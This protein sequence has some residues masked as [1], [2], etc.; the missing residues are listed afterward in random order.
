MLRPQKDSLSLY[1]RKNIPCLIVGLL[2]MGQVSSVSVKLF[3]GG[4]DKR[5]FHKRYPYILHARNAC[6]QLLLTVQFSHQELTALFALSRNA[7]ISDYTHMNTTHACAHPHF[8]RCSVNV[9]SRTHVNDMSDSGTGSSR[10][11]ASF[12]GDC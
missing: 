1:L 4:Y 11:F 2:R 9:A 8:N 10:K 7:R 6:L 12:H 3:I 5:L